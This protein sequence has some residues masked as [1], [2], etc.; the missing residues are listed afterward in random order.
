MILW[1]A[2]WWSERNCADILAKAAK[3]FVWRYLSCWR[4]GEGKNT[5]NYPF[6][7]QQDLSK[8]RHSGD[9]HPFTGA[10]VAIM[11]NPTCA[12]IWGVSKRHSHGIMEL[13][14]GILYCTTA[15]L[16]L[17]RNKWWAIL[18]F[19]FHFWD[20]GG[21]SIIPNTVQRTSRTLSSGQ[22]VCKVGKYY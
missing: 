13:S 1:A 6:C 15:Y 16:T 17:D 21:K 4:R 18:C 5:S 2:Y 22:Q 7:I 9:S 12:P 8:G 14:Q 19:T 10:K 20:G 11:T 3:Q